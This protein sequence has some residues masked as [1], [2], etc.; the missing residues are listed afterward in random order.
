MLRDLVSMRPDL[1]FVFIGP[2][3]LGAAAELP[4]ADN[5]L[6]LGPVG[7]KVLPSYGETFSVAIIPFEPGDIAR[8]TSPLKLFEY[9][10]LGKP[11]VVTADMQEC[12]AFSEVLPADSAATFSFRIDEAMKLSGDPGFSAHLKRLA[13]E[14]DWMARARAMEI[15]FAGVRCDR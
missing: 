1:G 5:L 15:V 4:Q 8:T 9:F 10:A 14:N 12:T 3:H 11:V 6:W 7:Y 2:D 13:E